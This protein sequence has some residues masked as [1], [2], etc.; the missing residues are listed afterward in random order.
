MSTEPR[1]I[2]NNNP[3]NIRLGTHW[4]GMLDKQLDPSFAQFTKPEYGIRAIVK[5]MHSYQRLG[6]HTIRQVIER[7]APPSENNTPAYIAAV[8]AE[9]SVG[10]D[11]DVKLENIMPLLVRAICYRENG[12]FP[13][14]DAQLA[15]GIELAGAV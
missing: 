9:C 15:R 6:I 13:Y 11:D 7:W 14:T 5:I 2:R 4:E 10:P 1:G 12:C 3:G 8:C